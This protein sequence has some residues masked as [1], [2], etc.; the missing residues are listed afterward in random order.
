MHIR[1]SRTRLHA[2]LSLPAHAHTP[3]HTCAYGFS[4]DVLPPFDKIKDPGDAACTD[5]PK[6]FQ[7]SGGSS[8][9]PIFANCWC[10]QH[11]IRMTIISCHR[12]VFVLIDSV[13]FIVCASDTKWRRYTGTEAHQKNEGSG[14]LDVYLF[15]YVTQLIWV[16]VRK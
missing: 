1:K 6:R 5:L 15:V 13:Y 16:L 4:P 7:T 14:C 3:I 11:E 9:D 10:I 8:P 2:P 12:C